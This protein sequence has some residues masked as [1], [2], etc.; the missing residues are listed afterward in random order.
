MKLILYHANAMMK[1]IAE[2]WAKENQIEVT[3]LSELLTAE[4][5]KLSKGYDGII[6]SQAAGT[7]DKEIYSTLHE[8]G[9]RQIALV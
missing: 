7:I 3:V 5:V 9:I 4:S 1:E 8:Y 6:N 2:N